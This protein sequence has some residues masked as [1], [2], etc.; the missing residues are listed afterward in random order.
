MAITRINVT[1]TIRDLEALSGQI[2]PRVG[3]PAVEGGARAAVAIARASARRRTG[4]FAESIGM[5]GPDGRAEGGVS[6][7]SD[8]IEGP[9]GE[10]D[11]RVQA[12]VGSSLW[13]A[14]F[15]EFGGRHNPAYQAVGNAVRQ[16][17]SIVEEG[18]DHY[19]DKLLSELRFR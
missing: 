6:V 18:L 15:P 14:K 3:R 4:T 17:D 5:I 10:S 19:M 13:Y 12:V 16:V 11:T 2:I 8:G 1:E 7:G 9:E